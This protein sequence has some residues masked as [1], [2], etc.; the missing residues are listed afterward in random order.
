MAEKKFDINA[1]IDSA[2]QVITDP[3]AFYR[4]MAKSGG[5]GDPIIFL[6]VMGLAAALIRIVLSFIGFGMTGGV[7]FVALILAPIAAIIGG[8]IGGAVMYVVWRLMGSDNNFETAFRC[9][10]FAGSIFPIT[11]ILQIIPYLGS[12]AA[13]AWGIYLMI[14]ASIGVHGIEKAKAAKVLGI[15]G[16]VLLVLQL[17]SE[18]Q[19][20]IYQERAEEME[21]TLKSVTEQMQQG[22]KDKSPEEIGE[23]VGEFLKGLEK[24]TKEKS[25]D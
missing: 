7:G 23:S 22:L 6:V 3:L 11:A 4:G 24:A 25:S 21:D 19:T 17:S 10:A 8:F 13:L 15:L 1:I 20:R 18:Y 2:R 9:V 12:I 14:Q 5:F 16:A